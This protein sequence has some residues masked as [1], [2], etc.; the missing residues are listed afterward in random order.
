MKGGPAEV[1]FVAALEWYQLIRLTVRYDLLIFCGASECQG[2][3]SDKSRIHWVLWDNLCKPTILGGLGIANLNLLNRAL[4]GK[5]Y[6]R[7]GNESSS[8]W[9]RV[10]ASKTSRSESALLPGSSWNSSLKDQFPRFYALSCN[11]GGKVVDFGRK[12]GVW[13][14]Y[15][16][17]RRIRSY[18]WK[19]GGTYA[20]LRLVCSCEAGG[21]GG[22]LRDEN[23]RTLFQFLESCGRGPPA[24]IELQAEKLGVDL[25]LRSEWSTMHRL[26]VESDCKLVT[27]WLL[28]VSVPPFCF[29]RMVEGMVSTI[30]NKGILVHWVPRCCNFAADSLAKEGIG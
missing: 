11:K 23:G 24:L 19:P 25:F 2:G 28:R 27:D 30:S 22:L 20:P 18:S 26:V 6:W 8:L 17:G 10:I 1:V 4:I 5:W 21:L 12:I 29:V 16:F 9:R 7:Y 15:L 14:C 13:A 3:N